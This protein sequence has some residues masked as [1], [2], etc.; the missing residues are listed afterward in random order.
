MDYD[1]DDPSNL[2]G[3]S[4]FIENNAVKTDVNPVEVE[5]DLIQSSTISNTKKN[6]DYEK[7]YD[8]EIKNVSNKY[9]LDLTEYVN[10]EKSKNSNNKN[11]KEINTNDLFSKNKNKKT[12]FI[13]D[14]F[15][16]KKNKSKSESASDKSSKSS[17]SDSDDS[18]FNFNFKGKNKNNKKKSKKQKKQKKSSKS[19]D[20]DSE[21]SESSESESSEDESDDSDDSEDESNSSS[22]SSSDSSNSKHKKKKKHKKT[23]KYF[24]IDTS[25]S[26]NDSDSS[27][28]FLKNDSKKKEIVDNIIGTKKSS[29]K[30][31][32]KRDKYSKSALI[33]DI[34]MLRESIKNH[35]KSYLKN[36]E[37]PHFGMKV[38]HL[39]ELKKELQSLNRRFVSSD[40]VGG[41]LLTGCKGLGKIFDGQRQIMGVRPYFKNFEKV[42]QL[43]LNGM[44]YETSQVFE[45]VYGDK[46][47]S[48]IVSLLSTIGISA[49]LYSGLADNTSSNE[50]KYNNDDFNDDVNLIENIR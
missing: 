48:P 31:D 43:K 34:N 50:K 35:N 39:E 40:I 38:S 49:L 44:K 22:D 18:L 47:I 30:K 15:D 19:S 5:R 3:I 16:K 12:S 28:D 26:D 46:E 1:I 6:T 33:A 29:K 37:K 23:S 7:L 32:K 2:S 45:S 17:D 21:S 14:I 4:Y 27:S 20:S 25:D 11:N 10:D 42:A 24:N 36:C 41:T 13:N 9:G 8:Q